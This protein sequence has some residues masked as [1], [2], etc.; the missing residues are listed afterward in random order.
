MILQATS[1]I[2][3]TKGFIF[4]PKIDLNISINDKILY[5]KY[6]LS[7]EEIKHIETLIKDFNP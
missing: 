3:L 7:D 5:E 1:S 2:H 4:V 6:D